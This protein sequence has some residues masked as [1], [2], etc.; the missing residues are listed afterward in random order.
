VTAL[1]QIGHN[2]PFPTSAA[3]GPHCS[4]A[5]TA[6][7]QWSTRS[8]ALATTMKVGYLCWFPLMAGV[9]A[10]LR[11][12]GRGRSRWEPTVLLA[13]ACVPCVLMPLV[14]D[15][16]PQD[17]LAMGLVLGGVACVQ[18]RSWVW[19]GVLLGLAVTSQQFALLVLAPLIVIVPA[20][21]RMRFTAAAAGAAAAIVLPMVAVSS[22]RALGPVFIGSGNT[23][24]VGGTVVWEL[25]LHGAL[26]VG[27]SRVLPIVLAMVL[28]AWAL[29]RLGPAILEPVPL[30]ALVATS[31]SLRL[32][33]EQNL[34][35]YYFMALAVSLVVLDAVRRHI[36]GQ[37][38][39]WIALVALAFDPAPW[40]LQ[41]PQYLPPVLMAVV[42]CLIVR[43]LLQGRI[44]WYL[45]AWFTLVAAAF[46]KFPIASLPLRHLLPTWLWQIILVPI[47][48][49]LALGPLISF[50]STPAVSEQQVTTQ[51]LGSEPQ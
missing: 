33:F 15:F 49:W 5:L 19:A 36:R 23:P 6:M 27:V 41:L 28:A 14:D 46:V 16:H 42:L 9:V 40:Q 24:S 25:H 38:V 4:T 3:L 26:L 50:K 8:E 18:R 34:F 43:D 44:R 10:V 21:R 17:L 11:A 7:T 47:G 39:A 30:M 1:A 29:R 51:N 45:L 48:F 13:V 12:S 37:L 22:G 20:S 35:G 2:V 31:L 32:V